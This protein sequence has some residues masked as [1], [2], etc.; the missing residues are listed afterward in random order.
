MIY[1]ML[2]CQTKNKL[3]AMLAQVT[4]WPILQLEFVGVPLVTWCLMI[5]MSGVTILVKHNISI[6]ED[7]EITTF[8][9]ANS[10]VFVPPTAIIT[11][12]FHIGLI[13]DDGKEWFGP[14]LQM[15]TQQWNFKRRSALMP[16]L[17][18]MIPIEGIIH[19]HIICGG[20]ICYLSIQY[21]H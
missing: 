9:V 21:S 8:Q 5:N 6:K 15:T 19:T 11:S 10:S 20:Q 12:T 13:D 14:P 16:A 4:W 17:E 3:L 7:N 2:G 1:S 18:G